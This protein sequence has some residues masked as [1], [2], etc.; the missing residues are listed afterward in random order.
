MGGP[1][2][3]RQRL[4]YL[5]LRGLLSLPPRLATAIAGGAVEVDGERLAPDMQ[6]LLKAMAIRREPP[7]DALTPK[8]LRRLRDEGAAVAGGPPERS[9]ESRDLVI[10]TG[11]GIAARRYLPAEAGPKPPLIVFFHG[12]GFVFGNL[13]SHD[14]FCRLFAARSGAQV[15]AVDYRLA[16]EHPFP[17]AVEDALAAL[18][19]A[20]ANADEL[21][22]EPGRIA[23]A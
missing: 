20:A 15:L 10:P 19:W 3:V 17:A 1:R 6:L 18:R 16:P 8:R 9:V 4:E 14:Q 11:S 12:G 7:I 22:A 2:T 5:L 21:G 23:V 13:D